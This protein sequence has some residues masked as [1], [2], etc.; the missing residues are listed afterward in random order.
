M[1]EM[2]PEMCP[3]MCLTSLIDFLCY[4]PRPIRARPVTTEDGTKPPRMEV[5]RMFDRG[6]FQV[7]MRAH[8]HAHTQ[9]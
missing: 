5:P 2:C 7:C 3:E 9:H 8:A 4:R 1:C 6:H